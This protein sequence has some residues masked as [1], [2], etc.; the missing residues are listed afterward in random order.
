MTIPQG[1][2]VDLDDLLLSNKAILHSSGVV[3]IEKASFMSSQHVV[4]IE[5]PTNTNLVDWKIDTKWHLRY[6]SPKY[7]GHDFIQNVVNPEILVT[8][9]DK[10]EICHGRGGTLE[11][12]PSVWVGAGH[13]QDSDFVIWACRGIQAVRSR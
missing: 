1:M 5:I 12:V 3:D 9:D 10:D 11:N 6:P 8:Q 7:N 13:E 4:I 2:F